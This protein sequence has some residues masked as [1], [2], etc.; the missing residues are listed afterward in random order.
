M[1]RFYASI[2]GHRGEATREGTPASGIIAHPRGWNLGVRVTGMT[3]SGVDEGASDRDAFVVDLTGGSN[4]GAKTVHG[5]VIVS[6]A[7][8]PGVRR[9]FVDVGPITGVTYLYPD[10]TYHSRETEEGGEAA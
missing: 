5:I 4:D 1:S 2:R 9:V 8:T 3:A 6:E 10:G 7:A